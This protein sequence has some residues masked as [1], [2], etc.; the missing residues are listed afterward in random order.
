MIYDIN[1]LGNFY[2]YFLNSLTLKVN[3]INL[4]KS[5]IIK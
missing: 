5:T 4:Y 1:T 3:T 2:L